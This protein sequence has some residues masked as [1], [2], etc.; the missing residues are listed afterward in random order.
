MVASCASSRGQTG[1]T[2]G[3]GAPGA[4]PGGGGG[5]GCIGGCICARA[6]PL[7]I[8]LPSRTAQASIV[9][10][11]EAINGS[12][13]SG[14]QGIREASQARP[15]PIAASVGSVTSFPRRGCGRNITIIADR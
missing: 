13:I 6:P 12:G 3:G 8:R 15:L 9:L 14:Q 7:S 5:G 1:L 10:E 4:A 11:E 2:A